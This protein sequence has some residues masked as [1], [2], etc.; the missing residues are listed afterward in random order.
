MDHSISTPN[1]ITPILLILLGPPGSGKGTQAKRITQEFNLPHISTGDLLRSHISNNSSIGQKA[2]KFMQQGL[3]VPDEIV[4]AMLFDRIAQDDCKKGFLLDGF[5]RTLEQAQQLAAY[6]FCSMAQLIVLSLEV[7]DEE[8]IERVTGRLTCQAC[9]AIYHRR[10]LA[11]NAHNSCQACGGKL[12]TRN[13]DSVSIISERL[14]V[15]YA[16]TSPLIQYYDQLGVLTTFDGTQP[17]MAVYDELK[18][19]LYNRLFSK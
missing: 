7:P 15:Y 6:P 13:D 2:S 5:P 4:M 12:V 9:G 8:I 1:S 14:K 3:L 16:Q 19:Y 17:P 10:M 11:P 18:K